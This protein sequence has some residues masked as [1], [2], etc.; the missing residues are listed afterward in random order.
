MENLLFKKTGNQKN[1]FKNKK[2]ISKYILIHSYIKDTPL[3]SGE[4]ALKLKVVIETL[5]IWPINTHLSFLHP[6]PQIYSVL[7]DTDLFK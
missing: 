2:K 6:H 1:Q 4:N 5:V 3:I 7:G